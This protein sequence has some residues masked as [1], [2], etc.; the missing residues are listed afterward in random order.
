MMAYS[1][2]YNDNLT[3]LKMYVTVVT[4]LYLPKNYRMIR[5]SQLLP[6]CTHPPSSL[7]GLIIQQIK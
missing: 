2:S 7:R 1:N 6:F 3:L 5:T 4:F